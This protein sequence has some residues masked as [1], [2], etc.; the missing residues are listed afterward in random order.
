MS[1]SNERPRIQSVARA[2][3]ILDACARSQHGLLA[4]EI[5]D[6]LDLSRQTTYHLLHT[7]RGV[8]LVD[9]AED[10]RFRLGL[11]FGMLAEAFERQLAPPAHLLPHLQ[12][13]T[14]RTGEACSLVGWRQSDTVVLAHLPGEHAVRVSDIHTGQAGLAHARASG[15]LLLALASPGEREEYLRR[16]PLVALTP[17]TI[18]DRKRLDTEFD[19]IR[20]DMISL[21]VE[22]FCEGI[23]CVAAPIQLGFTNFAL[24]ISAPADRFR[25]N[26]RE[27]IEAV[28]FETRSVL[29]PD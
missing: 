11:K 14:V 12:A 29:S 23:C 10:Q 27:Y 22:G 26:R 6:Q 16:H 24:S 20:R 25:R 4:K 3:A 9:K 19:R 7:L 18:T 13:L 1:E 5:A 2:A 28:R 15:K 21:D 8:G 17:K